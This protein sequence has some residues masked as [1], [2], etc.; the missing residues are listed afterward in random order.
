MSFSCEHKVNKKNK[1]LLCVWRL[2]T[3]INLKC[4]LENNA[5]MK[6]LDIDG[7]PV[8]NIDISYPRGA[9]IFEQ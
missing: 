7:Y 3:I 5:V 9:F 8:N 1:E 4:I 6:D 2:T